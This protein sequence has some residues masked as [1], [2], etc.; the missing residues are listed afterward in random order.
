MFYVIAPVRLRFRRGTV[1]R[2]PPPRTTVGR[3][4]RRILYAVRASGTPGPSSTALAAALALSAA[5]ALRRVGTS[6]LVVTFRT[7]YGRHRARVRVRDRSAAARVLS[8]SSGSCTLLACLSFP[9]QAI[10]PGTGS[11]PVTSEIRSGRGR[12]NPYVKSQLNRVSTL[13]SSRF[14]RAPRSAWSYTTAVASDR[15]AAAAAETPEMN[16]KVPEVRVSLAGAEPQSAAYLSAVPSKSCASPYVAGYGSGGGGNGMLLS[17]GPV[18]Q[19][20]PR[21]RHSWI[22]R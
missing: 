4:R 14:S 17:P 3:R 16:V 21:R 18:G 1:L 8:S 9:Y 2:R 22:C 10:N 19:A 7:P 6:S 11:P 5:A 12:K 15:P 13:S 20:A